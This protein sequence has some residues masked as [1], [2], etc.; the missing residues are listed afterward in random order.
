MVK[1][2]I[3]KTPNQAEMNINRIGKTFEYTDVSILSFV[4][5]FLT[6]DVEVKA[7]N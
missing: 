3:L 4:A 7:D 2:A 5:I 1:S 6:R